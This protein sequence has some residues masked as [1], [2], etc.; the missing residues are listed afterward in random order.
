M[1]QSLGVLPWLPQGWG[2]L[3]GRLRGRRCAEPGLGD[4]QATAPCH[5]GQGLVLG[6]SQVSRRLPRGS[7]HLRPVLQ[8]EA[9]GGQLIWSGLQGTGKVLTADFPGS[10]TSAQTTGDLVT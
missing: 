2:W 7:Q 5:Q 8:P 6:R 4:S 3:R 10:S 9:Q 1:L